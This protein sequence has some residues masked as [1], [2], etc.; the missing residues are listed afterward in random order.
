MCH[1]NG[2]NSFR[3]IPKHNKHT[4]L[5]LQKAHKELHILVHRQSL[6]WHFYQE[7]ICKKKCNEIRS[8]GMREGWIGVSLEGNKGKEATPCPFQS[9]MD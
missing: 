4:T 3:F 7:G 5:R 1:N 2:G 6:F 9:L 8:C